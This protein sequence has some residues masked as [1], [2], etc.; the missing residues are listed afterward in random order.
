[1]INSEVVITCIVEVAD[2]DH[3]RMFKFQILF[4]SKALPTRDNIQ[5]QISF[6]RQLICTSMFN[7]KQNQRWQMSLLRRNGLEAERWCADHIRE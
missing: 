5:E 3:L 7:C 1:M 2:H 4:A 6:I